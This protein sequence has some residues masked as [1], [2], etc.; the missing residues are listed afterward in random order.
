MDHCKCNGLNLADITFLVFSLCCAS[1]DAAHAQDQSKVIHLVKVDEPPVLDGKLDDASW[2]RASVVEDFHEIR[3]NEYEQPSRRTLVRVVYDEHA[4]YVGARMLEDHP[5]D[6][7]A[8]V[9][10]QGQGLWDDRFVLM[11]DPYNN[12]R[13]GYIFEL[14]PNGVRD[15]G[16]FQDT[17]EQNWNWSGI[18]QGAASVDD[19]GWVAE[20]RIPFKS[21]SFDPGN[22]TWGI[23]F[24]RFSTGGEQ[25]EMGWVSRNRTQNP[26]VFG[27][28]TGLQGMSQGIGLDVVPGVALGHRRD[29]L[30]G[31]SDTNTDPS[32]DAYYRITPN[33]TAALTVNTDFSGAEV[34]EVQVNLTRFGLFFPEQRDFFLRD[35][36]IFEF[37]RIGGGN[38]WGSF[39]AIGSVD[40]EN[41]R[42]FFS[43]RIGLSNTG[44]EVGLDGGVKL[45]GRAGRWD[46]G[47][48]NIVQ[49]DFENIDSS[50]LFVGRAAMGVLEESSIGVIVTDGHPTENLDSTLV[51][52]DFRYLNTKLS[53]GRTVE[54][55][56]W[57][58]KVDTEGVSGNDSAFGISLNMPNSVGWKGALGFRELEENFR[59]A[60]GFVNRAGVRQY[61]VELGYTHRPANSW[62]RTI[63]AGIDAQR[64]DR[65]DGGTESEEIAFRFLEIQNHR[66]DR[67][68]A[69]SSFRTEDVAV[70][71]T[72]YED[73]TD[74]GNNVVVPI[75]VYD[76]NEIGIDLHGANQR[77]FSPS[78]SVFA[79]D[80]FGGDKL[81]WSAGI[82]WRPSA[83]YSFS[84]SAGR[85]EIDLRP[86]ALSK[87]RR[88]H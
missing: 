85:N 84:L 37:G 61:S 65:L 46:F 80:F 51:G 75:G 86:R 4:L 67:L 5:S 35:T 53:N 40:R 33:I 13:S 74:P 68:R 56:M 79:G 47:V 63:F 42:P 57:Y 24:G 72:I 36:D 49:D 10:S 66:G 82:N 14:N 9:M 20:I 31:T 19:Q 6:I 87:R 15:D 52:V 77:Q 3:P 11:L 39:S 41:G 22:D 50:N 29:L 8:L 55:G 59:P 1:I 73:L 28:A 54:G 16:I 58:Q 76:N 27:K 23:N 48:L 62:L 18:W 60:M 7:N 88:L 12:E 43:R 64:Y 32:L 17:T 70:P 83:R 45:T 25:R 26:S 21:V 2:G 81:T 71:F 78:L 30:N 69:R 34:D 38:D 44:Q